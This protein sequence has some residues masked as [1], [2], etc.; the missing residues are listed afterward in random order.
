MLELLI[1]R[2]DAHGSDPFGNEAADRII[3]H[4]RGDAG[5]QAETVRQVGGAIELPAADVDQALVGFAERD[6]ARIQTVD[7]GAQ[8]DKVQRALPGN[9]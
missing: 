7:E 6:D 8:G 3:G 1:K 5:P 9:I 4:R 2:L